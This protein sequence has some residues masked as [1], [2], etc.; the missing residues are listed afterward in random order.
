MVTCKKTGESASPPPPPDC[1][2]YPPVRGWSWGDG[3]FGGSGLQPQVE[4]AGPVSLLLEAAVADFA[5]P[6]EEHGAGQPHSRLPVRTSAH[7]EVDLTQEQPQPDDHRS[8]G[9]HESHRHSDRQLDFDQRTGE[10][11]GDH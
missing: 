11:A 4:T 6:V 3:I 8:H 9:R 10:G 2:F 5:K 1:S 7:C